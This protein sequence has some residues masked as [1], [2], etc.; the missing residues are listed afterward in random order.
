[1]DR[2]LASPRVDIGG[3]LLWKIARVILPE[4]PV[5]VSRITHKIACMHG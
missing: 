4:F 2:D 1:M 3:A 5:V